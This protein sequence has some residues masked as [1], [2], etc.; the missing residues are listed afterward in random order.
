VRW[1]PVHK[2]NLAGDYCKRIEKGSEELH[3][4]RPV[5][6]KNS[7]EGGREACKLFYSASRLIIENLILP[8]SFISEIYC[9]KN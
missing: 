4:E 3:D 5:K 7:W 8:H 2:L 1:N 6:W 9:P